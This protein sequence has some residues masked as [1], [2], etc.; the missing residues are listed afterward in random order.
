MGAKSPVAWRS[1]LFVITFDLPMFPLTAVPF[2][3]ARVL[4]DTATFLLADC[5]ASGEAPSAQRAYAGTE[6]SRKK[7]AASSGGV[8]LM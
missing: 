2:P 5:E 6:A 4:D 8:G 1:G 3:L 7:R